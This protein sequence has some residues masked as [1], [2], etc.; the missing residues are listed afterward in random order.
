MYSSFIASFSSFF[1]RRFSSFLHFFNHFPFSPSFRS[2]IR[3][4]RLLGSKRKNPASLSFRLFVSPAFSL[5]LHFEVLMRELR[6]LGLHFF[7]DF[8]SS[9]HKI[10]ST[11]VLSGG[12]IKIFRR[13]F[14]DLVHLESSTRII[15]FLSNNAPFLNMIN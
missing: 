13:L 7:R 1:K 6:L 14:I 12:A 10:Y 2:R 3:G 11:D 8:S 4:E 9:F 15:H 5:F